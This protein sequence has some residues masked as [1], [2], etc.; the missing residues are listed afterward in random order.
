[1]VRLSA[2]QW[3]LEG[4]TDRMALMVAAISR[5]VRLFWSW[6]LG[7]RLCGWGTG[8]DLRGGSPR[9]WRY[10]NGWRGR[11]SP[12]SDQC[13]GDRGCGRDSEKS[14]SGGGALLAGRCHFLWLS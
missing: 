11:G 13:D 12:R 7:E 6:L 14:A 4:E 9:V 5:H 1:M 10:G 8:G 3:R 2:L